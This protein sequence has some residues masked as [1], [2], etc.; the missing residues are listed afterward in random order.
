MLL[1]NGQP[2][3]VTMDLSRN[4]EQ[5]SNRLRKN[6]RQLCR[7]SRPCRNNKINVH[8][9]EWLNNPKKTQD[10]KMQKSHFIITI[11]LCTISTPIM[12]AAPSTSC[13]SGYAKIT[14]DY[15]TI[16]TTT[17]SCQSGST[18]GPALSCLTP[19][20]TNYGTCI[21]YAPRPGWLYRQYRHIW[22][23]ITMPN[24]K[25]NFINRIPAVGGRDFITKKY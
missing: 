2:S 1:Q 7:Q 6:V 24:D 13:P 3:R 22:I 15:M 20:G 16:G 19:Q 8:Q 5:L 10:K 23:Y 9:Y 11:Y 17:T 25:L 12:A 18:V 4:Y 14:E 21:M